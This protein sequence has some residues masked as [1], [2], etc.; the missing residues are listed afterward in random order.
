MNDAEKA[1]FQQALDLVAWLDKRI[2]QRLQQRLEQ[3]LAQEREHWRCHVVDLIAAERERL[4][5]IEEE[6]RKL[7]DWVAA[8]HKKV[9]DLLEWS[10]EQSTKLIAEVT[11]SVDRVF[12]RIEAKLDQYAIPGMCRPDDDSQPPPSTH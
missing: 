4:V 1:R 6:C 7:I 12:D 2:E 9:A 8:D 11:K 5:L 3:R 10:Y